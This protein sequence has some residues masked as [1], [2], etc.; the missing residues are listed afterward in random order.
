MEITNVSGMKIG[1][2][3]ES[4]DFVGAYLMRVG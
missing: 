1:E 3:R 2:V 4:E